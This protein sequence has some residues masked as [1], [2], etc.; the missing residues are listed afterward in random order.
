[1]AQQDNT[2]R[3][4]LQTAAA[5]GAALGLAS[6]A[7]GGQANQAGQ[8]LP[9]RRLGRTGQDVSILC[10]GGWHIGDVRDDNEAIRIMHAAIDEG[11]NFF[12]N[13]WDYHDGRSEEIMGRA[14]AM[15]GKRQRVFLMTKN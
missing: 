8:G 12:D 2:R 14:L 5:G 15:D 7:D 4:F 10:L 6:L 13:A 11:I 3:E 1:M 9:R